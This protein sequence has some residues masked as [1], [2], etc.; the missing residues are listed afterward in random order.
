M[1]RLLMYPGR[2]LNLN[3]SRNVKHCVE[4]YCLMSL[5]HNAGSVLYEPVLALRI[6]LM[7]A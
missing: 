1:S 5:R 4:V 6:E 3:V 7:L 2:I